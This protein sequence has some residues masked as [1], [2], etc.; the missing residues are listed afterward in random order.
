M[1]VPLH[2][3]FT[4]AEVL[5]PEGVSDDPLTLADGLVVEDAPGA[6]DVALPEHIL[7]PGIVDLHGDAFERQLAPR[8]GAAANKAL[9]LRAVE[10]EL[11][12]SG[13]TT[14]WLAQFYSWEGGMRGPDFAEQ[15]AEALAHY[16]G[17]A[18]I[19]MRLQLRFEMSMLEDYARFEALAKGSIADYVVF[20]DHLPHE[21]LAAGKR[22]PRL[23]G[24]ALKARRS[25]E[26]HL[27]LQQRLHGGMSGVPAAVTGLAGQLAQVGIALGSHDDA[28]VEDRARFA[29]SGIAIS[30]FPLTAEVARHARDTDAAVIMGAPNVVRGGSHKS[31]VSATDLVRDGLVNALVSDYHYPALPQ[32]ALT[33]VDREGLSLA[34]AWSLI[35]TGPAEIMGLTDRGTLSPGHRADFVALHRETRRIEGC[36][37]AGR[38][39]YLSGAFTAALI[40]G[41]P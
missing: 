30:E 1:T 19:D 38:A 36:F 40:A 7:L 2:I 31:A 4:H 3:R 28:T 8:R 17:E 5:R 21:A 20:N 23:T 24:S 13:I 18:L 9:G 14:A 33:L 25:P 6:R 16:R 32:A 11:A 10:A 39:A 26:D 12:A 15:L 37:C 35:S 27:S 29:R 41:A 34:A 22:P